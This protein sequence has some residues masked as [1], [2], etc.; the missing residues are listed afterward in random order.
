MKIGSFATFMHIVIKLLVWWMYLISHSVVK[1]SIHVRADSRFAPIQWERALLYNDICHWLFSC[2]SA[3]QKPLITG[4]GL[5]GK[6]WI[7]SHVYMTV[8]NSISQ[9]PD[10]D[11]TVSVLIILGVIVIH[12]SV[13]SMSLC[14]YILYLGKCSWNLTFHE[15]VFN[16][17]RFEPFQDIS[18]HW[19]VNW[20][21]G[22]NKCT[23]IN[24]TDV[25]L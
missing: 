15:Y 6:I 5:K 20:H 8:A 21:F 3:R 9:F 23:T 18:K 22:G 4:W 25:Q 2:M 10:Y 19:R 11:E 14:L 12:N 16:L 13:G 1:T 17:F 24:A 7:I